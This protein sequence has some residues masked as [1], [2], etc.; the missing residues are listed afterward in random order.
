MKK[1]IG[2]LLHLV[3]FALIFN[4]G[5]SQNS[6]EP[7]KITDKYV[8]QNVYITS[9]AGQAPTWG[10]ILIEDGL[11]SQVGRSVNIPYDA[12]LIDGDSMYVY[13]GFIDALSHTGIKAAEE[14]KDRERPKNPGSPPNDVAGI[15]PDLSA[16]D[17]LSTKEKSIKALRG[18]GITVSHVVPDGKMLPGQG[19]I[20]LL[21]GDSPEEMGLKENASM[22]AQFKGAGRMYPGTIIGVMAKFRELYHGAYYAQKHTVD[23]NRNPSGLKRPS[24]DKELDA[25][26]P[27]LDKKQK[28]FF[29]TQKA[30][31]I[32]RALTLQKELGFQ[33]VLSDVKQ[34]NQALNKIKSS[35]A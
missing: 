8:I 2:T 28:I 31:T 22:Y 1:T 9:K 30:L 35:R 19:A 34:A 18:A 29:K 26:F 25:F 21:N 11:I 23:Y 20:I 14:K 12:E 6:D 13:P 15:T 7:A 5:Y 24:H 27:V 17:M 10:S 4:F 32:Q 33:I 3:L 16:Y